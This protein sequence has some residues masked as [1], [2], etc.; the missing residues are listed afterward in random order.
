VHAQRGAAL[1]GLVDVGGGNRGSYGCGVMDRFLNE[2]IHISYG[3]GVSAG[4]AN[5]ASYFAGQLGRNVKF[6][7]EY[8]L[9]REAISV[10]NL[11][12]KG[13]MVDVE[14]IYGTITNKGG[15]NPL[16]FD[17]ILSSGC[18]WWIVATDAKTGLPVYF[19]GR[20]MAQDDFGALKASSNIPVINKPY[21]WR[22]G[23]YFD[24]GMSDPIPVEK[25]LRDGCDRV[26]VVLTRPKDAFRTVGGD[27]K[28]AKM[29]K[30]KYPK[31]GDTL[32]K[33]AEV[34]NRELALCHKLEKEGTVKIVA[35]D[36]IANMKTLSKDP[37][38]IRRLYE[39]GWRDAEDAFDFIRG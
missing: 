24:G 31:A 27:D 39:N 20:D 38:P 25:A 7:T 2:G 13:S 22:G 15:E 5:L 30:R 18:T 35:P 26:V 23:L 17:A 21:A 3:V 6:Y 9:R 19:D 14:Y 29:L 16:D 10:H 34:Y 1:V 32:A 12:C 4:S 28:P 33:R 11:F 36:S 37:E 8:N